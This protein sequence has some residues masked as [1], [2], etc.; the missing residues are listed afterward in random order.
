MENTEIRPDLDRD[1]N[2]WSHWPAPAKLNLFLHVVG[3]RSDGYHLLQTVFQ[4]LDWG[5]TVALRLRDDGRI[6]RHRGASGVA[7]EDDLTM[8]AANLLKA[9]AGHAVP[10][11]EIDIEKRI[12]QGGG[13][14][15]GSSDAATVLLVLNSLWDLQLG[16]DELAGLGLSLGADVPVF[17]RGRSA[18]AEGV[19][20]RLVPLALPPR[21][22]LLVDP[23][24]GV[25]T[26]ELFQSPD[27]TRD[28]TPTTIAGFISGSA[29]DNVFEPLLRARSSA[30][31]EALDRLAEWGCARVTGTGGGVFVDFETVEAARL[32]Q[33]EL[34]PHWGSRVACGVDVSPLHRKLERPESVI[35]GIDRNNWGVA[36]R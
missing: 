6:V 20:E 24:V 27:L 21:A 17:V 2:A 1:S 19:G 35:D 16:V 32:A 7:A 23:G 22:Y 12:P 11:V 28:C 5:D 33:R 4:L 14:G 15:G 13:F 18:F 36:K 8:R 3:R 9:V 30:V 31:A 10:G 29:C 26:A 25:P 34:P